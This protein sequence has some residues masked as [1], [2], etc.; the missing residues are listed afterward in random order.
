[1]D[2]VTGTVLVAFLGGGGLAALLNYLFTRR[3][4][5]AETTD[6]L[7]K[8]AMNLLTKSREELDASRQELMDARSEIKDL[9]T[10]VDVLRE[11]NAR[12]RQELNELRRDRAQPR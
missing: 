10:Q 2:P 12:L 5:N 8:T 3:K 4:A 9:Q 11:E 1:M 7:I 6:V